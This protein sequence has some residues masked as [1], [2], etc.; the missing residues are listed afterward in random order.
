MADVMVLHISCVNSD[1]INLVHYEGNKGV[2]LSFLRQHDH[3]GSSLNLKVGGE[4][5]FNENV[6]K[7]LEAT[8]NG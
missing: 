6:Y 2:V 5:F 7:Y 4:V 3:E 1:D 8:D